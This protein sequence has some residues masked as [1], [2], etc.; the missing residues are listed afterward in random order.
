MNFKKVLLITDSFPPSNDA[1]SKINETICN[2]LAEKFKVQVICPNLNVNNSIQKSYKQPK[3]LVKRIPS[4]FQSKKNIFL[5]IINFIYFS[6]NLTFQKNLYDCNNSISIIHSSPPIL[7]P[8][9]GIKFFLSRIFFKKDKLTTLIIHDLYP[10]ILLHFKFIKN[11][12]IIFKLI[13]TIYKFSYRQYDFLFPCCSSIKDKLINSYKIKKEKVNII[14]CW[15]LIPDD[16][17]KNHNPEFIHRSERYNPD[18]II[19]GNI[20]IL[21]LQNYLVKFLRNLLPQKTTIKLQLYIRGRKSKHFTN[22]IAN[23]KNVQTNELLPEDELINVFNKPL[24]TI[25]SLNY[26][27]CLSAFPSRIT[28]ALSVGSPIIFITDKLKGNPISDFI[29]KNKIGENICAV[30]KNSNCLEVYEKISLDF[31][32]YRKNALKCYE[33]YFAREKNLFKLKNILIKNS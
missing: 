5:K 28:T 14:H 9:F 32:S 21:H 31:D 15:S 8:L 24:L 29:T 23:L 18:L 11:H 25:V 2:S 3:F 33:N 16:K 1:T 17:L 27:S 10:D 12:Q 13:S 26:E 4:L 19:L 22:Q 7:I 30:N 20:G 6:I